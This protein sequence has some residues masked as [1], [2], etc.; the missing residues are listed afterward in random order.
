MLKCC[1][2]LFLRIDI[3]RMSRTPIDKGNKE[4]NTANCGN[5][6]VRKSYAGKAFVLV[7][8]LMPVGNG[9]G[10]PKR[11]G[12]GASPLPFRMTPTHMQGEDPVICFL[13]VNSFPGARCHKISAE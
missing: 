2:V 12:K 10:P 11:T 5:A 9:T 1:C 13:F 8:C 7:S 6:V 3:E 4:G